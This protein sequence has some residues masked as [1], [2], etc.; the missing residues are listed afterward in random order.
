MPQWATF[1]AITGVV[2]VLLLVLSHLTQLSFSDDSDGRPDR[3]IGEDDPPGDSPFDETPFESATERSPIDDHAGT[4]HDSANREQS[5]WDPA[6]EPTDPTATSGETPASAS[7]SH[8]PTTERT[9]RAEPRSGDESVASSG[10]HPDDL[11]PA[12]LSTGMLLANVAISQGLFALVLLGAVLYTGIPASA[13]GVEFSWA[14]L[15]TG[16]LVGTAAGIALYVANELAAA[17]ATRLGFDHDEGLREL[18]APESAQGWGLLLG[19]VLP[20][21]AVFEELLFRAALIGVL[22][23]GFD[24]SP[25]LLAVASSIAFALGHGMQGTVGIVVT[26]VLGFVL[27]AIFIVTGSLLVVVVAHYWINA[28][29]FVIHEGVGL[30]WAKTIES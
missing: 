21:I 2:L 1:A 25:W 26:G 12:S 23:A 3:P 20:I 7:V 27:A 8:D 4:E 14:Y 15:E 6:V 17:L 18:L 9:T 16:L 11:D 13:L 10:R 19:G 28:L 5:P 24:I 22:S 30:E 29:E